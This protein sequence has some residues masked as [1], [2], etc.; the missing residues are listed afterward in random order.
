MVLLNFV[1]TSLKKRTGEIYFI[2]NILISTYNQYETINKMVSFFYI[3]FSKSNVYFIL[4]AYLSA[5]SKLKNLTQ[6]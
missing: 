6:I 1:V 3:K 2:Q 5:N 4:K